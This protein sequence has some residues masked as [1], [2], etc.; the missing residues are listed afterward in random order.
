M[1][2]RVR[3]RFDRMKSIHPRLDRIPHPVKQEFAKDVNINNIIG[4]MKKGISPPP[5]MTA[6]T[7]RYGDFTGG[8]QSL[9]EAFDVVQRAEE[10]FAS[11]PLEFR[12][13]IDHDPRNIANAPREL[14]ERFGLLKEKAEALSEAPGRPPGS[15]EGSRSRGGKPKGESPAIEP[16]GV[17]KEGS[18]PPEEP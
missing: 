3:N 17:K 8:P 16:S 5:W 2:H 14:F 7:P 9:M 1:N 11:L 10:A 13:E 12:R 18:A 4:K 6:A 15:P